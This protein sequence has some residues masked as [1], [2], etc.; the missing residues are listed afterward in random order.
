MTY[1]ASTK[2]TL[3]MSTYAGCD[4]VV[5]LDLTVYQPQ[6]T[7][8]SVIA[9]DSFTWID[10]ITYYQSNSTAQHVLQSVAG[11][12]SVVN[13]NLIINQS[14]TGLDEIT[15]CNNYTWIDGV[16]YTTSTNSP[17]FTLINSIGCDSVVSLNLTII[18]MSMQVYRWNDTLFAQQDSVSYQWLDCSN[19]MAEIPGATNKFFPIQSNGSYAV[20]LTNVDC[21]DTSDC[22]VVTKFGLEEMKKPV[23]TIYPNPSKGKV[24][25]SWEEGLEVEK[26]ELYNAQG[27]LVNQLHDLNESETVLALDKVGYYQIKFLVNNLWY[28]EKIIVVE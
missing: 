21:S 13:L 16:T 22:F 12:D 4:S 5:T 6:I 8:D 24:T 26:L 23:V 9:C 15:A 3:W 2:D 25:I 10:G 1:T 20:E 11:C 17:S 7:L 28:V 18:N 27:K 19:G 14:S